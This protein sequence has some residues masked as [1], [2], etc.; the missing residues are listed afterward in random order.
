MNC[1]SP[2]TEVMMALYSGGMF[3][4]IRTT[5][6]MKYIPMIWEK[7]R[8][9]TLELLEDEIQM[10]NLD[11]VRRRPRVEVKTMIPTTMKENCWDHMATSMLKPNQLTRI[12]NVLVMGSTLPTLSKTMLTVDIKIFHTQ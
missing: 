7:K 4:L 6:D 5:M 8:T 2:S 12:S 3:I 9:R 1:R 11:M 10:K